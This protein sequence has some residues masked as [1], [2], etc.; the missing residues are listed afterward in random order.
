MYIIYQEYIAYEVVRGIQISIGHELKATT[1]APSTPI[2]TVRQT[3][4]L[5]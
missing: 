3:S 4:S 2:L 1:V 5:L